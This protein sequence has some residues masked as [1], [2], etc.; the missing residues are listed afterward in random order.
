MATAGLI[1][2][3]TKGKNPNHIVR[4]AL[5]KSHQPEIIGGNLLGQNTLELVKE[6]QH[7]VLLR[8][9]IAKPVFHVAL[10]FGKGFNATGALMRDMVDDYLARMGWDLEKS[11]F[12][13]VRHN[14]TEH[15]HCHVIA[16]RIQLD[17]C[18]VTEP[19]L[20]YRLS[21]KI[22][23]DL[24]QKYG[25]E[26]GSNEPRPV[27]TQQ[28][29]ERSMI[30]RTGT[31]S[32]KV[33]LQTQIAEAATLC[34]TMSEFIQELERRDIGL[35]PNMSLTTGRVAGVSYRR[36]DFPMK[37]SALGKA[38]SWKGLQ[39]YFKLNYDPERDT[40][41]LKR[42]LQRETRRSQ[43]AADAA[44]G[45]EHSRQDATVPVTPG[46]IDFTE[47]F[48][49][50]AKSLGSP[51]LKAG[52]FGSQTEPDSQSPQP[53]ASTFN[54]LGAEFEQLA[55]RLRGNQTFPEAE[56]TVP[57]TDKGVDPTR[58]TEITQ[59]PAQEHPVQIESQWGDIHLQRDSGNVSDSSDIWGSNYLDDA[60]VY[61]TGAI[62][63]NQRQNEQYRNKTEE[64]RAAE[65]IVNSTT[66][67]LKGEQHK[68]QE[69]P[70]DS[71]TPQPRSEDIE[72]TRARYRQLYLE[73][74]RQVRS[75]V[76]FSD[77][78]AIDVEVAKL[79]MRKHPGSQ[80]DAFGT[81]AQSTYV[82]D[83]MRQQGATTNDAIQHV[84]QILNYASIQLELNDDQFQKA[85][86]V[87]N[88][89]QY[90]LDK[91]AK[92]NRIIGHIYQLEREGQELIVK[93]HP[94]RK[95]DSTEEK[96][97]ILRL[98]QVRTK[99]GEPQLYLLHS[100]LIESDWQHFESVQQQLN[101][102]LAQRQTQLKSKTQTKSVP[103]KRKQLEL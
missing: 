78:K 10:S 20:D 90:C 82:Q 3:I 11:Q 99:T 8:P 88:V 46:L 52:E 86:L 56:P 31:D 68:S 96:Q 24:E 55:Q 64:D 33:Q 9:E 49:W 84:K 92:G 48:E 97:E 22:C 30:E 18:L 100:K 7:S 41:Q 61:A 17:G 71:T 76:D 50:V 27:I 101:K 39:R 95:K 47:Q 45:H 81:I 79:A 34:S 67:S 6:F 16:S 69:T 70:V 91:Y 58:F 12:V 36:G 85:F 60:S 98:I 13:I 35:L 63:P 57:S 102:E 21:Q 94:E 14:D 28:K 25:L 2:K 42:V 87:G 29:D 89:T 62:E 1:A 38:F 32:I 83:V 65:T 51:N 66:S 5:K 72:A 37:G 23:R 75:T 77:A 43:S 19:H 15:T 40:P 74:S 44:V 26:L 103:K 73:Y 54:Q 59:V 93:A 53:V 4:Y 80:L